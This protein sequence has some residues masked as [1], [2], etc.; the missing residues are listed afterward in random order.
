MMLAQRTLDHL[1]FGAFEIEVVTGGREGDARS[2][3]AAASAREWKI[4]EPIAVAL[5]QDDCALGRVA[6]GADIPGPVIVAQGGDEVRPERALR[7]AIFA[8]VQREIM[9]EQQGDIVA[10]IDATG[11]IRSRPC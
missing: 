2:R 4:V 6:Q 10:P 3:L 1:P 11:A 8:F 7:S 5:G 9:V